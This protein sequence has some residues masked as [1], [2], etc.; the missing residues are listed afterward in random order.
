M[1]LKVFSKKL[2]LQIRARSIAEV[3]VYAEFL[4]EGL[5]RMKASFW[6]IYETGYV[7]FMPPR[8]QFWKNTNFLF[9][10]LTL[11]ISRLVG[12]SVNPLV[13]RVGR[14]PVTR[15]VVNRSVCVS[16]CLSACLSICLSMLWCEILLNTSKSKVKIG[17][18]NSA[19]LEAKFLLKKLVD[20]ADKQVMLVYHS[21]GRT[22]TALFTHTSSTVILNFIVSWFAVT[23][24]R[25]WR[26]DTDFGC[27]RTRR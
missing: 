2:V 23:N 20:C 16:I 1:I 12:R 26:V 6:F 8:C 9:W 11:P 17:G 7:F 13:I 14:Q 22:Q 5:Q 21:L 24:G 4:L 3:T 10:S 19:L 15:K 18:N 25:S 27:I